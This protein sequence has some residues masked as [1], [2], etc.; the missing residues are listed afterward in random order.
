MDK[1]MNLTPEQLEKINRFAFVEDVDENEGIEN[2]DAI[3]AE[4]LQGC[5]TAVY[6]W[7]CANLSFAHY[8]ITKNVFL[9]T[10]PSDLHPLLQSVK[11]PS[12]SIYSNATVAEIVYNY[13]GWLIQDYKLDL[14]KKIANIFSENSFQG[15]Q[16]F[17]NQNAHKK[18]RI[19]YVVLLEEPD[20]NNE[21]LTKHELVLEIAIETQQSI[22]D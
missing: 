8:D 19:P 6:E 4:D 5:A 10:V 12:Y 16:D 20:E 3:F 18:V 15:F 1:P 21:P 14:Q 22:N 13:T 9:L 11:N 7:L 2:P 17:K